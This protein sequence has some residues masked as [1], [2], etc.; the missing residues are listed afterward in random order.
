[1]AAAVLALACVLSA[2]GYT[3]FDNERDAA[4]EGARTGLRTAGEMRVAEIARWRQDR[5]K[6]A[7]FV[8]SGLARSVRA[9]QADVV[10][11][12]GERL[13]VEAELLAARQALGFQD[14]IL[15]SVDGDVQ[16][17]L[18]PLHAT[19][20]GQARLLVESA[21]TKRSAVFGELFRCQTH[22]KMAL[23][24]AV[25]ILDLAGRPVSVLISR[26][27]SSDRLFPLVKS[28]PTISLSA[29]MLLVRRDRD[30]A[31]LL[32]E[33]RH[34][35]DP[36]LTVRLPLA[37]TEFVSVQAALGR[38]GTFD[39]L[40]YRGVEVIAD[41]RQVEGS[42]WFLESEIDRS[43]IIASVYAEVVLILAL[44]VLTI[45]IVA[46]LA[47][48]F[49]R[50]RQLTLQRDRFM[51]E[52]QLRDI[53]VK[54]RVLL[55]E[56]P[57]SIFFISPDLCCT[58]VN[59]AF[60]NGMGMPADE[61]V[62][63]S[64]RDLLSGD[65]AERLFATVGDV[66][67]TG[68]A[69]HLEGNLPRAASGGY[70]ETTITPIK[71]PDGT[72]LSAICT[73]KDIT[74][75]QAAED[76]LKESKA[77]F[78][79]VVE[80]V[81]LMIFLKESEDLRFVLFNRAG[82]ELLGYDRKVL[83]G[84]NNL[85][86]FPPQQAAYFT[87]MDREVLDGEAGRA[88]IPEEPLQTALQ[89]QRLLHT[90]KVRIRG[91]DGVTKFLLGISEDITDRRRVEDALGASERKF[92]TLYENLAEGVSINEIVTN[93]AGSVVD[94]RVLDANPA[95][96]H[97][98]GIDAVNVVG[99]LGSEVFGS[100]VPPFLEE[101]GQVA[102]G[103]GHIVF[104]TFMPL[105]EKH[106]RISVISPTHGQF[107]TVLED[108]TDQKSRE[109]DLRQKNDELMRFTTMLSH[110]LQ[111]PLVTIRV[112]LGYL[113]H[114]MANGLAEN[115]SK[116]LGFIID[117]SGKMGRLLDD[118]LEV[119][120]AGRQVDSP[121]EMTLDSL[122]FG[123]V[124]VVA[125]AIAARGV[126]V[127]ANALPA[128]TLLGDRSRLEAVWQNL[129]ENAVKYM[130]DQPSPRIELGADQQRGETVF[131]VKDNGMGIDS[132]F[133]VKVFDLFQKLDSA[134]VG[135]GLGLAL[136]KRIVEVYGGRIWV[137]SEGV[138]LGTC[139][140]FTLPRALKVSKGAR[141]THQ[142]TRVKN[143]G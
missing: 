74:L 40:D 114:D 17:S 83:I 26:I 39:G 109:E 117:A 78:E 19:L 10:G 105:L 116:D 23:D 85:D 62:G 122:I 45:L 73:S 56:S 11:S 27:D 63:R 125:G 16:V 46:L 53:D 100:E 24:I 89:G 14:L 111:S 124:K 57:D 77:L 61:I 67:R 87:L 48:R 22:G 9:S 34:W 136:V 65:E 68:D 36:P 95:Y 98:T 21:L 106:F 115:V 99:R 12:D 7:V 82:E 84:Q 38:T 80:N 72:V 3:Y 32:N 59:R 29:E 1:L 96:C 25:P 129:V 13:D 49:F 66:F 35:K 139:F 140:R 90:R 108:I 123:S 79:A 4:F 137:E 18:D 142:Q 101:F 92:R 76:A 42:S 143:D 58:H 41:I 128:I 55:E 60:A 93:A 8:A 33:L 107:A 30:D 88:D 31:L 133:H 112:F 44:V 94:Y 69:R 50:S 75:R 118:L 81:P 110:D 5:L 71:E 2:V 132:R 64:M 54:Y 134:S 126:E 135:T 28:W 86:L 6:E 15:V 91:T 141:G 131:F 97:L 103:G 52:R 130:G 121:V 37:R 102:L 127:N 70:Y 20:D 47:W 104:E 113:Q 120:K 43:E 138:G 51:I 119:S